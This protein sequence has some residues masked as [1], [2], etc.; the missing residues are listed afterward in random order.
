MALFVRFS[1]PDRFEFQVV[2]EVAL[3]RLVLGSQRRLPEEGLLR[4]VLGEKLVEFE[5]G[6]RHN[7]V[8]AV[9][10]GALLF[11]VRD[12]V[13]LTFIKFLWS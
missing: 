10:L 5:R 3:G 13:G 9:I 12:L 7:E 4:S 1:F 11:V 2:A 8:I 6:A